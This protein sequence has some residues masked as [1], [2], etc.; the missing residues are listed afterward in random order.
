MTGNLYR[1]SFHSSSDQKLAR[2]ISNNGRPVTLPCP[3]YHD[4]IAQQP[5]EGV[6]GAGDIEANG[7]ESYLPH[8]GVVRQTAETSKLWVVYDT[9]A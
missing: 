5:D 7:N 8:K 1:R 9:S 4:V 2:L 6:I 3:N